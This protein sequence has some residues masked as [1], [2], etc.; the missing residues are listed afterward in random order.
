MIKRFVKSRFLAAIKNFDLQVEQHG[1]QEAIRRLTLQTGS[2]L[3][4]D[5]LNDDLTR[6]LKYE[7]VVVAINHPHEFDVFALGA[8]M[9]KR[10]A[11]TVLANAMFVGLGRAL[12]RYLIPL[13][14]SNHTSSVNL[15]G[16]ILN[17]FLP[18]PNY[19]NEKEKQLN[20]LSLKF[21]AKRLQAGQL[22]LI[23]PDRRSPDGRWFPG[24]GR[25]LSG[26]NRRVWVAMVHIE[27]TSKLDYLHFVPGLAK[28]LP[29]VKLNFAPPFLINAGGENPFELT[30][31][32]EEQYRD[33]LTRRAVY[34]PQV[35]RDLVA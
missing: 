25:V 29:R 22:L 33:W 24:I 8:V 18:V 12:D 16:R 23:A 2:R 11:L 7:P 3:E 19:E 10:R 28:L 13:Y 6:I 14:I 17:F 21:A 26:V 30:S 4:V 31:K 5:G 27:G 32:L 34:V 20:S 9:P 15:A 1:I 35:E